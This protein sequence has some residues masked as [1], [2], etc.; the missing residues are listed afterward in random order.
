[1]DLDFYCHRPFKCL[2]KH[3]RTLLQQQQQ[4]QSHRLL[5]DTNS[6][7]AAST[8]VEQVPLPKDVLVV[9][10]EPLA[11]AV[12]FR[13][14]TRVVIQVCINADCCFFA[15]HIG[16]SVSPALHLAG[17]F[18]LTF[19]LSF[20]CPSEQ[21]FFLSTPKHPFFL[22]FLNDRWDTFT[23]SNAY[24]LPTSGGVS[25]AG[26]SAGASV[27]SASGDS[28]STSGVGSGGGIAGNSTSTSTNRKLST[29][30]TTHAHHHSHHAVDPRPAFAKGPFSYSIE[31]D[32]DRYLQYKK[33][34]AGVVGAG[35][36][37]TTT[38]SAS[39]PSAATTSSTDD[40]AILELHEDLMHALIDSTNS[41][42]HSTC[43]ALKG[44]ES[45]TGGATLGKQYIFVLSCVF[46]HWLIET[47]ADM[48]HI[49]TPFICIIY[50]FHYLRCGAQGGVQRHERRKVL[51]AHQAHHPGAYVDTCVFRYVSVLF[52][53]C[54]RSALCTICT[55][56]VCFISA[57]L[58]CTFC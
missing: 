46:S 57:F 3:V 22:W 49:G 7:S 20:S 37:P 25:S 26:D 29:N 23:K 56:C 39:S 10:R 17:V 12:L 35:S 36:A 16:L 50:C 28:S 47:R 45:E 19:H 34:K 48:Q 2:L 15:L 4:Q 32:I 13:N 40:D 44:K 54:V 42:L 30:H 18:L 11:H 33:D 52:P 58:F 53:V 5:S 9:S 55:Q 21:D 6:T 43:A 38:S 8:S 24:P 1:M 51:Q 31:K 41:R 27:S 14:M